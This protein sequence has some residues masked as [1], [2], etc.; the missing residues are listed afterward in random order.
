MI[1]TFTKHSVSQIRALIATKKLTLFLASLSKDS[2]LSLLSSLINTTPSLRPLIIALLPPPTL[3]ATLATVQ[4]LES[5]L[6][7]ALPSGQLVREDY[8]WNR[9]KSPLEEYVN[10]L[11][12]FLSIFCNPNLIVEESS[13]IGHPSTTFDFLYS[14]TSSLRRIESQLPSPPS[15]QENPNFPTIRRNA[16]DLL[17]TTLLPL[18]INHWHLF[19]TNLIN[20][21]Q[22]KGKIISLTTLKIWWEKLK[23]ICIP[24]P[25]VEEGIRREGG[26]KRACEGVKERFRR[27]LGDFIGLREEEEESGREMEE[28]EEL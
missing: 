2:L 5:L 18:L 26:A 19:L 3:E 22:H 20:S 24:S 11:K 1:S 15:L 14:L 13:E 8:I 16:Q 21:I 7:T 4:S 10:Q 25:G 17:S 28:E 9:I 23:G 12:S 27:E 6:L